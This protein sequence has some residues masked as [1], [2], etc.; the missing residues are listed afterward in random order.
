M[1]D[2]RLKPQ[3]PLRTRRPPCRRQAAQHSRG[4]T[5]VS[6]YHCPHAIALSD[7]STASGAAGSTHSPGRPLRMPS[8]PPTP[9]L[10]S[11][12]PAILP[13]IDNRHAPPTLALVVEAAASSTLVLPRAEIGLDTA[14]FSQRGAAGGLTSRSGHAAACSAATRD[15]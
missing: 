7:T 9:L 8:L 13:G 6:G 12:H 11:R 2:M 5:A 1:S 15:A 3:S 14:R 10:P 4:C